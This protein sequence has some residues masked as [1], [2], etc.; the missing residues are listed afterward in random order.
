GSKIE[1][2][3]VLEGQEAFIRLDKGDAK[4][5]GTLSFNVS[6]TVEYENLTK[7]V[8]KNAG[9]TGAEGEELQRITW[10]STETTETESTFKTDYEKVNPEITTFASFIGIDKEDTDK[11]TI[12][13]EVSYENLI[14]GKEYTVKGKLMNK[15]T[16]EPVLSGG[17]EVT[18]ET[19][20]TPKE[21]N[22]TVDVTFTFDRS[23]IDTDAV[24]V[25]ED[26]Y[27]GDEVVAEHHDIDDEKQTV[28]ITKITTSASFVEVDENDTSK[29]TLKDEVS[30]EN[31]VQGEEYTVTGKLMDKETGKPVMVDGE[32]VTSET[33]FTVEEENGNVD[34]YFSFEQA[35]LDTSTVVV[36]EDVYKDDAL[37]AV[38][39]D[40]DD[41]NQTVDVPNINTA[42]SFFGRDTDDINMVTLVDEITYNNLT[43]DKEYTVKGKLMD[44][45]TEEPIVIDG[46]EVTG[47]TTFTA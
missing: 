2:S 34:V 20:F 21:H 22:G 39:H 41:E 45:E 36:F 38:H 27:D 5:K 31:L 12:V 29:V 37:I 18:G 16:G 3:Q 43:P 14:G 25:F 4:E 7:Y 26:I 28:Y 35:K 10:V 1:D 30:Y 17:E 47:E 33:V 8:P 13:D 6:G 9:D 46:E 11:V 44:K 40:I 23:D 42:A 24:V 19:K 15:E 32:E